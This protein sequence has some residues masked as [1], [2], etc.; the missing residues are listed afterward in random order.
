MKQSVVIY[1]RTVLA[2]AVGVGIDLIQFADAYPYGE[3]TSTRVYSASAFIGSGRCSLFFARSC[4]ISK[5]KTRAEEGPLP[6]GL[7]ILTRSVS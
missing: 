4:S 5:G 6:D 1:I 7:Q 2:F 3:P